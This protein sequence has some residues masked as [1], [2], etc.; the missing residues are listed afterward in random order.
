M[1]PPVSGPRSTVGALS[2]IKEE[3]VLRS[4]AASAAL[5]SGYA[6]DA[7]ESFMSQ[8]RV[9]NGQSN[10]GTFDLQNGFSEHPAICLEWK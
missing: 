10:D 3:E 4:S 2:L 7:Y 6:P 1:S 9:K 8:L 5:F